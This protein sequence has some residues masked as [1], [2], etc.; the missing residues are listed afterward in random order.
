MNDAWALGRDVVMVVITVLV[1]YWGRDRKQT[2]DL[3]EGKFERLKADIEADFELRDQKLDQI[4]LTME[5]ANIKSSELAGYVQGVIGRLDRM[6]EDLRGKFLSADRAI[7]LIEESRRDRIQLWKAMDEAKN[8]R[9]RMW[10]MIERRH[11]PRGS[12]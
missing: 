9:E 11:R 12:N 7:D 2:A 6:P 4:F 1:F 10:E 3:I 5:R 8:D